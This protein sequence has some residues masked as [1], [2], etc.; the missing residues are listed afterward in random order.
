M[1]ILL[2]L[3]TLISLALLPVRAGEQ[4]ADSEIE[5]LYDFLQG[6]YHLIGKRP[7]SDVTF[8]GRVVLKKRDGALKVVRRINGKEIKGAGAIETATAD[9]KKVLRIRF[10]EDDKRWEATYLI[11][12][13]LDN[14]AR[15]SGYLYLKEGGT[16]S[17]GLEALFIDQQTPA[18]EP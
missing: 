2:I 8:S 18:Q 11:H 15:L 5:F 9:E 7:D 14:Y 3:T 10:E 4:D 17:P 16:K 6:A 13:D 12:S 1:K